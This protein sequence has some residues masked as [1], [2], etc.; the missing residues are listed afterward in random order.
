MDDPAGYKQPSLRGP[1]K[2]NTMLG[3]PPGQLSGAIFLSLVVGYIGWYAFNDPMGLFLFVP[4]FFSI[5]GVLKILFS[6]DPF[7]YE[8][9]TFARMPNVRLSGE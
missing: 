9:L 4:A 1:G 8:H 7:W 5:V 3:I 6:I 2:P